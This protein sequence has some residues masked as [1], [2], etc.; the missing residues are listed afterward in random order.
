M[1]CPQWS[2]LLSASLDNMLTEEERKALE[3]HLR[4]CL[5]CQKTL[6]EWQT[7][8]ARLQAMPVPE[9]EPAMWQRVFRRIRRHTEPK[10]FF[11]RRRVAWWGIAAAAVLVALALPL[12]QS[13]LKPSPSQPPLPFRTLVSYHADTMAMAFNE[14]PAWHLLATAELSEAEGNE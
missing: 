10:R 14:S 1:A 11:S 9:P 7:L 13:W 8:R 3:A 4:T 5:R 6:R 2:E 12:W